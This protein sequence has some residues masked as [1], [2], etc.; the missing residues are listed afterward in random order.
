M[1]SRMRNV[2]SILAVFIVFAVGFAQ[3]GEWV[4]TIIIR[5]AAKFESTAKAQFYDSG[6]YINSPSDGTLGIYS[7]GTTLIDAD[8]KHGW[9]IGTPSFYFTSIQLDSGVTG[10]GSGVYDSLLIVVDVT[11]ST[12]GTADYDSIWIPVL[13]TG[14]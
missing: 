6:L 3:L 5:N 4:M 12:G 14:L 8:T 2:L 7:D 10:G 13:A 9:K 11:N 1:I